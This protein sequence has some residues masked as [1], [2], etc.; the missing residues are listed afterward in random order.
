MH[1]TI[2]MLR[3]ACYALHAHEVGNPT[4]DQKPPD[5]VGRK[6]RCSVDW[7]W[8]R[9]ERGGG[10][11]D[12]SLGADSRLRRPQI[13]YWEGTL[14]PDRRA[15]TLFY[16][17]LYARTNVCVHGPRCTEVGAVARVVHSRV[18]R[19]IT[20]KFIHI[21]LFRQFWYLLNHRSTP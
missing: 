20:Y 19:Y 2:C 10:G 15:V 16:G 1:P 17:R 8:R 9:G 14:M 5:T 4:A 21:G 18:S 13:D 6:V 11:S 3:S 7:K 12:S